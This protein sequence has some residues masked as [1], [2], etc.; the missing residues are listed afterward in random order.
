M[1]KKEVLEA[2]ENASNLRAAGKSAEAEII[3]K[4]LVRANLRDAEV[5]TFVGAAYVS[6][7]KLKKAKDCFE[8]AL[9]YNPLN[10]D[11]M[12]NCAKI[13]YEL[14]YFK[15]SKALFEKGVLKINNKSE[16]FYFLSLIS[17]AEKK[18]EESVRYILLCLDN[19]PFNI[20]YRK[21]ALALIDSLLSN[22]L[23][24]GRWQD[25]LRYVEISLRYF[26]SE[27]NLKITKARCLCV[28][29]NVVMGLKA[30]PKPNPDLTELKI[31]YW[32]GEINVSTK[33]LVRAEQGIG[34]QIL[35]VTHLESL[36]DKVG[37]LSVECD[38]RLV[39]I[40]TQNFKDISF[41]PWSEPPHKE[42]I[43][44]KFTSQV[45]MLKAL[46]YVFDE[47]LQKEKAKTQ[48]LKNPMKNSSS[49]RKK[50]IG[51]DEKK[52]IGISWFSANT[53]MAEKKTIPVGELISIIPDNAC[54]ISLQYGIDRERAMDI[55]KSLDGKLIFDEEL[56]PLN[57]LDY[58][59]DVVSA[60]DLVICCSN[61]TA[62]VAGLLGVP[63]YVILSVNHNWHWFEEKSHSPWYPSVRLFRKERGENWS[64]VLESVR[65]LLSSN[66]S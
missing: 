32:D 12:I 30:F 47:S 53:P 45:H 35:F 27:D 61:S 6:M 38:A 15:K 22:Y 65:T 43:D 56:D 52:I 48:K 57:D 50:F 34:E 19:P 24:D 14:G 64:P 49:I 4:N 31:P 8:R 23:D 62:H 28:Q 42:I 54:I 2:I 66:F 25:A 16:C 55:S 40:L 3:Y 51:Q 5:L 10:P 63:C 39:N 41:V 18:L 37:S 36:K 9:N 21:K 58:F 7:N 59:F 1:N 44:H 60:C 29:G 13:Y 26:P 17:E 20:F 33:L 11:F 46:S